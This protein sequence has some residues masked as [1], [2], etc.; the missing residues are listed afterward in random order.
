MTQMDVKVDKL[1]YRI[2]VKLLVMLVRR[3]CYPYCWCHN[4][5]VGIFKYHLFILCAECHGGSVL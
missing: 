2:F 5:L 3:F 4:I 1:E